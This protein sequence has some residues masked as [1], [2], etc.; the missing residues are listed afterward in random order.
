MDDAQVIDHPATLQRVHLPIAGMTCAT[1]VARVEHALNALPGVEATVNLAEEQADVR[2]DP[3]LTTPDQLAAAVT[4]AGYELRPDRRELAISGM[5]CASCTGRVEKALAAVPG[6]HRAEVNLATEH[7]TVDGT[8]GLLRP[9]AL[10]EAVQDA[11]YDATLLT[12]DADQLRSA[13]AADAARLHRLFLQVLVA[14]ALSAPLTLPMFG[15]AIAGWP[16]AAA[17]HAGAVRPRCPLLCRGLEGAARRYR[18]HGLARRARHHRRLCLQRLL[19]A[20]GARAARPYFDAAAIV[21][22][23]V[24]FGRWL[25]ARAQAAPPTAAIRA[26]LALRP[27]TARVERGDGRSAEVPVGAVSVG[28]VVVVRPGER[29][30]ADGRVLTGREPGRREP[31][32]RREPA[33]GQSAPATR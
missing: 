16:A 17:R 4:G 10:I 31:A 6:V 3:H 2:F 21:I 22:T 33:G 30:P 19:V 27:E 5:T 28:D 14:A 7:A 32:H 23:L 8:A 26:L 20:A 25:E 11:G 1:C 13:E 18:Q 29:I 15:V 9:A 24:L 12:G